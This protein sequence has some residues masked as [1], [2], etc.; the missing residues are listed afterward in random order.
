MLVL[1]GCAN[2]SPDDA[3]TSIN[4]LAEKLDPQLNQGWEDTKAAVVAE[5]KQKCGVSLVWSD[6]PRTVG[7][8]IYAVWIEPSASPEQIACVRQIDPDFKAA[9][10]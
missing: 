9:P 7:D 6:P 1:T 2:D 10:K 8:E 3:P 4:E 5:V